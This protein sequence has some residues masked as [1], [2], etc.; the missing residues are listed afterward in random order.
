MSAEVEA[1]LI[2]AALRVQRA[3]AAEDHADADA[4][5]GY[6]SDLLAIAARELVREVEAAP[7][8]R[9]PAGWDGSSVHGQP[10]EKWVSHRVF[11]CG[12]C[13]TEFGSNC[14]PGDV[15]CAECGAA[16]CANCG[17]WEPEVLS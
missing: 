13:G 1:K 6:A 14:H 3:L 8:E 10:D 17:H 12:D 9:R 4:G 2:A 5:A 15:T 16:L 7:A 11:T